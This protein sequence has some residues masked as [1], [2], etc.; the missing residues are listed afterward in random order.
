MGPGIFLIAILGCGEDDSACREVQVAAPRY[1]SAA[2]CTAATPQILE[3]YA[4]LAFPNVVAQCRPAGARP[5][6]LR[7]SDVMRPEL[8]P[9]SPPRFAGVGRIRSSR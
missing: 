9:A 6:L 3:R 1:E 7:G 5:A 2:A 4:D 8:R